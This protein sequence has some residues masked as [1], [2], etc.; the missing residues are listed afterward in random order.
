MVNSEDN[1][2]G[3]S[4]DPL[5]TRASSANWSIVRGVPEELR[6]RPKGDWGRAPGEHGQGR[7]CV[8]AA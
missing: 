3:T 4:E 1:V 6:F 5:G 7:G 2:K 8:V